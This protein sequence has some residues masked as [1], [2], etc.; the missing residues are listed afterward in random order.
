MNLGILTCSSITQDLACSSFNC[1]KELYDGKGEFSVYKGEAKLVGII[2]CSGCLTINAPEKLLKRIRSLTE[3]KPDAI[4][5]STCMVDICPFKDKYFKLL[6]ENFPQI[7]FIAGTHGWP[8]GMS[9]E[10]HIIV[11]RKMVNDLFKN[12]K[13]MGD[14][15]PFLYNPSK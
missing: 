2:N 6:T 7:Q 5:L 3:L 12:G 1:L 10:D 15:I 9:K 4:H 14:M 13:T 8:E 11:N